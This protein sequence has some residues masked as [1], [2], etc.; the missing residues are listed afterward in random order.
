MRPL[1]RHAVRFYEDDRQ[2][3]DTVVGHIEEGLRCGA[4]GLVVATEAHREALRGRLD[5]RVLLLD[6]AETLAGILVA[7]RPDLRAFERTVSDLLDRAAPHPGAEVAV[8]G[9]MVALLVADGGA[10]AALE[11]ERLWNRL[12]KRRRLRLLCAYPIDLFGD[13][14]DEPAFLRFC[15][16]HDG[17]LPPTDVPPDGLQ[18]EMAVLHQRTR[19]L[20]AEVARWREA[21]ALL[22]EREAK[23]WGMLADHEEPLEHVGADGRI[24]WANRAQLDLLGHARHEY[25][26]HSVARFHCD[27]ETAEEFLGSLHREEEFHD[28]Y[29]RLR[30]RDGTTRHVLVSTRHMPDRSGLVCRMRDVTDRFILSEARHADEA[31]DQR[32]E[33]QQD[34]L[35]GL[36]DLVLRGGP[37]VPLLQEAVSTVSHVLTQPFGSVVR[38]LPGGR[39]GEVVAATGWDP[40]AAPVPIGEDHVGQ[41]LLDWGA[42]VVD[43]YEEEGRFRG[44]G[45]P[46]PAR[47]GLCMLI[48]D[49]KRRPWGV[50]AVHGREDGA[51]GLDDLHFFQGAANLLCLAVERDR[52]QQ[53]H[54]AAERR[55]AAREREQ[56]ALADFV[57]AAL[58]GSKELA[59]E[60]VQAVSQAT[61]VP[62]VLVR[63]DARLAGNGEFEGDRMRVPV[64]RDGAAWGELVVQA[65]DSSSLPFVESVA[66]ALGTALQVAALPI[67]LAARSRRR[68]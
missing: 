7:G 2:L 65:G 39:E 37:L 21:E 26:G 5:G 18:R 17:V 41:A 58:G 31:R 38:L 13:V 35:A 10:E 14:E 49:S 59:T 55:L 50:L 63:G 9:E 45:L 15:G 66:A 28:R 36:G 22:A 11:L 8:F 34:A 53:A 61:G 12:A 48:E 3:I 24:L 56:R 25:V 57:A 4:G 29:A 42:V 6:A 40:P 44:P 32:R 27:P 43:D 60:A 16:E 68:D 64:L 1:T 67:P 47:S 19:A 52:S 23:V 33:R 51:F 46:V 54:E 30:C 20:E 62:C